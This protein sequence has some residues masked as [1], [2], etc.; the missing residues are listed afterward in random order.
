MY[1]NE[2]TKKYVDTYANGSTYRDQTAYNRS[3]LGDATGEI[4]TSSAG[5]GWYNDYAY[6]LT[7]SLS[8]LQRGGGYNNG[9]RAGLF[10][11][12]PY[13]GAVSINVSSRAS[14]IVY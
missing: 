14:L 13:D 3:R 11:F 1:Y 9:D 6:I 7:S 12:Y 5:Y 8:W 10:Y 2:S 4:V